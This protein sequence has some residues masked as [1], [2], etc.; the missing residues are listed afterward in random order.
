M[1]K[2]C[3][4]HLMRTGGAYTVKSLLNN[5]I[6][7][8]CPFTQGL[9]RDWNRQE[10]I[11]LAM[12]GNYG[13][14]HSHRIAFDLEAI[15]YL[16]KNGWKI[17]TIIRGL[18]DQLTSL[19]Y[20]MNC[21]LT[22]D[23]FIYKQVSNLIVENIDYN[24]WALPSWFKEIDIFINYQYPLINNLKKVFNQLEDLNPFNR[25]NTKREK[26]DDIISKDTVQILKSSI[27]YERYGQCLEYYKCV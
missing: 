14:I 13:I 16:K 11:Q 3:F 7:L 27:Y 5:N 12:G 10:I 23:E 18:E 2:H 6:K 1:V 15:L 20:Y 4:V 21:P 19:W 17:F 22:L 25:V 9:N 24:F 26:Y 8:Y